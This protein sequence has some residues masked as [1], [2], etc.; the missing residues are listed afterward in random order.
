MKYIREK[1]VRFGA[2]FLDV[3]LYE[4][5]DIYE[6]PLK[7]AKRKKVTPP[8]I[9]V[10]NERHSRNQLRQLIMHNFGAGDYYLTP[11]YAGKPPT[12]EDAQR[13]LGNFITRLKRL[14]A[15]NGSE[16]KAIYV[17]EGGRIKDE[18]GTCTRVH[19]HIVI[20]GAGVPREEIEKCWQGR[21]KRRTVQEAPKGHT[22]AFQEETPKVTEET[23]RG[24]C[25]CS[26]IQTGEDERGCERIA[27][28]MAKSRT[29]GQGKGAHRW[30]A[31][32]NIKR[33][34][35]TVIDNKFSRKRTDELLDIVRVRQ[36]VK[37]EQNETLRR[38]LEKRYDKELHDVISTVNPVT[39]RVYIS[40]RFKAKA[41]NVSAVRRWDCIYKKP[42][43][44]EFH[45]SAAL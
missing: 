17:T 44:G 2:G 4:M 34:P 42:Q 10:A 14:Y 11:T 31:T 32:R 5:S 22:I 7:R 38:I 25:N 20:N 33:P 13:Q 6:P 45:H 39:G 43:R 3:D 23:R 24:Y 37:Q 19:H 27:E 30:N 36:A 9:I 35:E 15:K 41:Q 40:A 12:L 18:S 8:H 16:L 26:L 1:K 21:Q 28:Y 29:K